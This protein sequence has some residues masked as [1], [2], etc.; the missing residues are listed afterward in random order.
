MAQA[1]SHRLVTAD[2]RVRA[3]DS[4]CGIC[5]GQSC[6]GTG[7]LSKFFGF[8]LPILFRRFSPHSHIT[9]GINNRPAG[10]RGS[11]T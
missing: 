7:F 10:G 8:P 11:E 3:R 1:V 6:T 5:G 2:V 9:W 4:P